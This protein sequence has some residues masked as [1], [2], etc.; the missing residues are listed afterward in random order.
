MGLFAEKTVKI[1]GEE[2]H[3]HELSVKDRREVFASA[4]DENKSA[5]LV[6]GLLILRGCVEFADKVLEDVEDLPG[7]VFDKLSNEVADL[8]GMSGDDDEKKP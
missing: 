7:S 5:L 6:S 4:D 3:I 8:S 1:N 2:F